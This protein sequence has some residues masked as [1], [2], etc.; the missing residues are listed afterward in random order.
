MH[1]FVDGRRAYWEWMGG[2]GKFGIGRL[3]PE[4]LNQL[5]SKTQSEAQFGNFVS[6]I[7]SVAKKIY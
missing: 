1:Q 2:S 7:K 6:W 5:D 3:A 4:V